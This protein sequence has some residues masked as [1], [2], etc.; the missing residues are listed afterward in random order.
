MGAAPHILDV[1]LALSYDSGIHS[2]ATTW[3]MDA[4]TGVV[5]LGW[6]LSGSR[7][8]A[9]TDGSTGL[10]A[11]SYVLEMDGV[12]NP[13]VADGL[14]WPYFTLTGVTFDGSTLPAGAAE[15]F[16]AAG[17]MLSDEVQVSATTDGWL[18]SDAA[19]QRL[20]AVDGTSLVVS[21]GGVSYQA[22]SFDFSRIIYYSTFERWEITTDKGEVRSYGGMGVPVGPA[23]NPYRTGIGNGIEWAVRWASS[24]TATAW[25][26]ASCQVG[27]RAE[28]QVQYAR[29]WHLTYRQDMAGNRVTYGY[30]QLEQQGGTLVTQRTGANI[31]AGG[32]EQ[33]VGG[34]SGKPYTKACYLTTVTDCFG[35]QIQLFYGSK[36]CSNDGGGFEYLDPHVDFTSGGTIPEVSGYQ[37][38]YET[39][40]LS[41]IA[42]VTADL[43]PLYGV[44]LGYEVC[45]VAGLGNTGVKRLL[46]S[47]T[48]TTP[49]GLSL[50]G[51]TY[52]Y[53]T[54]TYVTGVS[55]TNPGAVL[56]VTYPQGAVATWA[57]AASQIDNCNRQVTVSAPTGLTNWTPTGT[58]YVWLGP[59]YAVALWIDG[60]SKMA[61]VSV[62]T[63]SGLWLPCVVD[64][65]VFNFTDSGDETIIGADVVGVAGTDIF[66]IFLSYS[67]PDQ[68]STVGMIS[69]ARRAGSPAA[70][71]VST[72]ETSIPGV[73]TS[74]SAGNNFIAATTYDENSSNNTLNV[75]TWQ[76]ATAQWQSA[77]SQ[78]YAKSYAV[79]SFGEVLAIASAVASGAQ[80]ALFWVDS[81][82]TLHS[83]GTATIVSTNLTT[84]W[85]VAITVG[86][87]TL[88][89]AFGVGTPS[90]D[91]YL[92]A[93]AAWSSDYQ[94]LFTFVGSDLYPLSNYPGQGA[95]P[96]TPAFGAD[97]FYLI[98]NTL[99]R[100]DGTQWLSQDIT[101]LSSTFPIYGSS[102]SWVAY[103][104]G[105]D[106]G[107]ISCSGNPISNYE[108][109]VNYY[110]FSAFDNS[111][112]SQTIGPDTVDSVNQG[113]PYCAGPN[114]FIASG[115]VY[116][117]TALS[118]NS[119]YTL[120][121]DLTSATSPNCDN[122][123]IV[124]EPPQFIAFQSTAGAAP[125]VGLLTLQNGAVADNAPVLLAQSGSLQYTPPGETA[126]LCGQASAGP[127]T[128]V[129]WSSQEQFF[130]EV[131]SYVLN[132]YAGQ[133]LAGP[134][135]AYPVA[136][137]SWSDGTGVTSVVGYA[138]DAQTAGC[139][140]TG[141][142]VKF[143]N[144]A[145]F[146]GAATAQD[147]AAGFKLFS[148]ENGTDAATAVAA[149]DGMPIF[150]GIVSGPCI[151]T[152]PM[153][154]AQA[155]ETT[156]SPIAVPSAVITALGNFTPP[157]VLP[158]TAQLT[159]VIAGNSSCWSVPGNDGATYVLLRD[160]SGNT[161]YFVF[162]GCLQNA[163]QTVWELFTSRNIGADTPN[164]T[165]LFGGFVRPSS[166]ASSSDGMATHT[167][168]TYVPTTLTAPF[169]GQMLA[170]SITYTTGVASTSGIDAG[171]VTHTESWTYLPSVPGSAY[172]PFNLLSPIVAL[173]HD[174]TQGGTTA[175]ISGVAT[176][177]TTMPLPSGIS[178]AIAG[179][180]YDW[181]GAGAFSGPSAGDFPQEGV[182]QTAST[183]KAI[184]RFGRAL[185][186]KDALGIY[187]STLYDTAGQVIVASASNASFAEGQALFTSFEVYEALGG[188][189]FNGSPL[190]SATGWSLARGNLSARCA[191]LAAGDTLGFPTLT[192]D[193]SRPL[194][195]ALDTL[196]LGAS[197]LSASLTFELLEN[198]TASGVSVPDVAITAGTSW[199]AFTTTLDLPQLA[200]GLSQVTLVVTLQVAADSGC[201]LAVDAVLVSPLQSAVQ[202]FVYDP[203]R[204]VMIAAVLPD[205]TTRT[206]AYDAF[207]RPVAATGP[208]G[209]IRSLQLGYFSLQGNTQF[210]LDDPNALISL[211]AINGGTLDVFLDPV[212]WQANWQPSP[213]A[214][215]ATAS[216][217]LVVTPGE[218]GATLTS[219]ASLSGSFA[220]YFE[221]VPADG[222]GP[223]DVAGLTIAVGGYSA[224]LG[225]GGAWTVTL[226]G[227]SVTPQRATTGLL[228]S[229]L[230]LAVN[231]SVSLLTNGQVV[232]STSGTLAEGAV[233]LTLA[234]AVGIRNLALLLDPVA[235]IRFDDVN[236]LTLQSQLLADGLYLTNQ[237]VRDGNGRAIVKT[238]TAPARFG[239][240][241]DLPVPAFRSSF[242]NLAD[243]AGTLDNTGAMQGDVADYYDGTNNKPGPNDQGYP[244]QRQI[245]EPSANGRP[246]EFGLPGQAQ[247]IIL[248]PAPATPQTVTRRYGGAVS[249]V[250][251]LS[252][253][254]A[255]AA[256]CF[257]VSVTTDPAGNQAGTVLDGSKAAFTRFLQTQNGAAVSLA[258][259]AYGN[260]A[261]VQGLID[262]NAEQAGATQ[263]DDTLTRG[264]SG[265]ISA[266]ATADAGT[267][268]YLYDANGQVRLTQDAAGSSGSYA[269]YYLWDGLGRPVASGTYAIPSGTT[270]S[271]LQSELTAATWPEGS[272]GAVRLATWTWDGD[273]TVPTALG[274]L[275]SVA[276]DTPASG[277]FDAVTIADALT[278]DVNG[279]VTGRTTTATAG[280]T[281]L[282]TVAF[283]Y[284]Y[285]LQ[286]RL[287]SIALPTVDGV[288]VTGIVYT[289][290]GLDRIVGIA[291]QD[292]NTLATYG[293]D[294]SGNP[295]AATL[296]AG[297][298]SVDIQRSFD[299]ANRFLGLEATCGQTTF[300]L[301][302]TYGTAGYLATL[303]ETLS[304][305]EATFAA[306]L[307]FSYDALNRL[308]G[309]A[310][311]QS[312]RTLAVSY[313]TGEGKLDLNG[314]I[315]SMTVGSAPALSY[316]YTAGS[317]RIASITPSGGD[318]GNYS[319]VGG[320][321]ASRT[322]SGA[323]SLS[324]QPTSTLP[325]SVVAGGTT[326]QY[327]YNGFGDRTLKRSTAGTA[328]RL[329]N[330]AGCL[331]YSQEA[332]GT[333]TLWVPGPGNVP[334]FSLSSQGSRAI[335][336]DHLNSA[337]LAFRGGTLVNAYAYG[338]YGNT[339][340]AY[341]SDPSL[342]FGF[343]GY[344]Y[345]PE[346]SLCFC[347]T[348][349]YDP[350]IGRFL[351]PDPL[352]Q[353]ADSYC[354]TMGLPH[355]QTD[356][357]GLMTWNEALGIALD[358]AAVAAMMVDPSSAA[359]DV[360][361]ISRVGQTLLGNTVSGAL[362]GAGNYVSNVPPGAWTP[363]GFLDAV[364]I[365]AA[366]GA[367]AGGT[368]ALLDGVTA[369]A[370]SRGVC[371]VSS[372]E[373]KSA[374]TRITQSESAD[375][376]AFLKATRTAQDGAGE[377][378]AGAA[379]KTSRS[380][381]VENDDLALRA[382][383]NLTKKAAGTFASYSASGAAAQALHRYPQ[384]LSLPR[385]AFGVL[386]SAAF[387]TFSESESGAM[388]KVAVKSRS[389]SV[390]SGMPSPSGMAVG[391][392][393]GGLVFKG[394]GHEYQN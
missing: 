225:A 273:G 325:A 152:I 105:D 393:V 92:A 125:N 57:Y 108:V 52:T 139:D 210:N 59:D 220:L 253:F 97:G 69:G 212:A 238:K 194:V 33:L 261:I 370:F 259:T 10:G 170:R 345:D 27:S 360:D 233:T 281:T 326:T 37:D 272:S 282:A 63:W 49:E 30:N 322:G 162:E 224:A 206:A 329:Y 323:L 347:K 338:A 120:P 305:G 93:L 278:Y 7:I 258:T 204:M 240:G 291:D 192:P 355:M 373:G 151:G 126:T 165:P 141:T 348:R 213:V 241:A 198:G 44:T 96:P 317:N 171:D 156:A 222:A 339:V 136:S 346:S 231:G 41:S 20:F 371:D 19:G 246:V 383:Y 114:F 127:G 296:S 112:S 319:Y 187:R 257:S 242:V 280:G 130:T 184:D 189:T 16:L 4:P 357:S 315:Q 118:W 9:E 76:W 267:L 123:S 201:G 244:Y 303:T 286:G 248:D 351:Q 98:G 155:L 196:A 25:A 8:V 354:Y 307:T 54:G 175:T 364:A 380:W 78:T 352:G 102:Y 164:E 387:G 174:V 312:A 167:A 113:T 144:S 182:W 129:T 101:N 179:S 140:P 297:T 124:F 21:D 116:A 177:W 90:P 181:T 79:G 208:D 214:D 1:T 68:P 42:V 178:L 385:V 122:Q 115:N 28:T 39:L 188:W 117:R 390:L 62:Y 284:S 183:V 18:I 391:T 343:C 5:G 55:S 269:T 254:G 358:I 330:P 23:A 274:Q 15:Q 185:E 71:T 268:Q 249:D 251:C 47:I 292:G 100:F 134:I 60:A 283:G 356:P 260:A 340:S 363:K 255:A 337:R 229:V 22:A 332:D 379:G 153:S 327:V 335:V 232:A 215:V 271:S 200:A 46:T 230:L 302:L 2:S 58:P 89:L 64:Q 366:G 288:A 75:W 186:T 361:I 95:C 310:D 169:N 13:L 48:E 227:D 128:L 328:I 197:G 369:S 103:G 74:V 333:V 236:G 133:A 86:P 85:E 239:G 316:S 149:M 342:P 386:A 3:N 172:A 161:G 228:G 56:S 375:S 298:S 99:F 199:S 349:L 226:D 29:A 24:D 336:Y 372:V 121:S 81:G 14:T 135:D 142:T 382:F 36:S 301:A 304:G 223:A 45:D 318:A 279:E 40:Y 300:T 378:A 26:G 143:Y 245:L 148:Y 275:A 109:G 176:A 290:D 11:L 158:D 203:L 202:G 150:S 53:V 263:P 138:F 344:E 193:C 276:A 131:G 289:Y 314:N 38:R 308:S 87:S 191:G 368:E 341:D 377:A 6:S 235:A 110:V 50:P 107:L 157:L 353:Y 205:G 51:F 256:T 392:I 12:A 146:P 218:S 306:D 294:A 367:A 190:E 252:A 262:P 209:R 389:L 334:A 65:V 331:T 219:A 137:F 350:G 221:L 234:N 32:V 83:G 195:I 270:F 132:R 266:V 388:L 247:A 324:Y 104:V 265:V 154:Q 43:T 374:V 168:Y 173:Q 166:A 145:S 287:T 293:Y 84:P 160:F 17:I 159:T 362:A 66:S 119:V 82:G 359:L 321:L 94:T 106:I 365:S 384:T 73:P 243:F 264:P 313:E 211:R 311:T 285:D 34:A 299:S 180:S 250:S 91:S 88:A 67:V 31:I 320:C 394:L 77:L 376:A 295:V 217:T 80:L 237:F 147:A 61:S 111:F 309:V 163:T 207:W 35:R 72:P 70:W 381:F 277:D 216:G